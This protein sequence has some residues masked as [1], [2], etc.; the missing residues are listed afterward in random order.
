M[1]QQDSHTD[2]ASKSHVSATG[3]P[4][5]SSVVEGSLLIPRNACSVSLKKSAC[6]SLPVGSPAYFAVL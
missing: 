3:R 4:K 1:A 6:P 2:S 5:P